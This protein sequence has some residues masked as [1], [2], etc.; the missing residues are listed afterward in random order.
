MRLRREDNIGRDIV[1]TS[2]A[3]TA[4]GITI[5]KD[6]GPEDFIGAIATFYDGNYTRYGVIN[7]VNYI[8][9][10]PDVIEFSCTGGGETASFSYT[11]STGH[12][13]VTLSSGGDISPEPM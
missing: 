11:R 4:S 3:E 7:D 8:S 6:L 12:L 1:F 9:A 5:A 13:T 2:A 10:E